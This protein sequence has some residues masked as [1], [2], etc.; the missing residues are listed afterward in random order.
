MTTT[1]SSTARL[2]ADTG[3]P[4]L[5]T[6]M[7]RRWPALAFPTDVVDAPNGS[8]ITAVAVMEPVHDA[9]STTPLSVTYL[10]CASE[11]R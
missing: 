9:M 5:L 8:Q 3:G 4:L 2:M 7:S 1:P 11:S 10:E 6:R